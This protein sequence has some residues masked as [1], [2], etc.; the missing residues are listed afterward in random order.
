MLASRNPSVTL[1]SFQGLSLLAR[2][3]IGGS[4]DSFALSWPGTAPAARRT[5]KQVQ[6]DEFGRFARD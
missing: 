5:L 4:D 2:R 1:N 3:S 6:H